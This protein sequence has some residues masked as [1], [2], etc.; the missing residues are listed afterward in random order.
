MASAS[1]R[2]N[3][4][5]SS[6][7]AFNRRP[8][9]TSRPLY[10][11]S[12]CRSSLPTRRAAGPGQRLRSRLGLLQHANDLLLGEPRSLH[13]PSFHKAKLTKLGGKSVDHVTRLDDHRMA[14]RNRPTVH[15]AKNAFSKSEERRG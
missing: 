3:F 2:L 1:S 15:G 6:P 9:E 10:L 7:S 12:S 4:A 5:F 13:R 14:I 8:S 11:D